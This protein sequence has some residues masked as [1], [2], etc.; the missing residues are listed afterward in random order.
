MNIIKW[1]LSGDV[2]IVYQVKRDILGIDDMQFKTRIEKEGY[3]RDFLERQNIN[4]HWGRSFYQPKWTSSHYTLLDL[5]NL[6]I[7]KTSAI[8]R[9]IEKILDEN[10]E[11]DGGVN[12]HRSVP[13]SDVCIN[14]MALDYM[15]WFGAQ[16]NKLESIVDFIISQHMPDGGF[17]C[18]LN[19]SGAVHSSLH[20]TLSVLEGIR[21]YEEQGYSYRLHDLLEIEKKGREFILEHRLYKSDKTGEIISKSFL[22]LS[23][24]SRWKYDIL[25]ALVYFANAGVPYDDRMNDAL[26]VLVCKQ[27]KNGTWPVQAKHPG[28]VHFD[29][30]KT[31]SDSRWN[32]YRALKVLVKYRKSH[33]MNRVLDKLSLEFDRANVKYGIGAS[34]LLKTWGLSEFANDIDIIISYEDREKAIRVLDELGVEKSEKNLELYSTELFKTYNVDGINID[35][36][37]NFTIKTDEGSYTYP[38]DDDRITGMKVLQCENIPTMS[39]ENWLVAYDL[40]KRKVKA[41]KIKNHLV[42]NGFN[43]RIIEDALEKELNKDTRKMLAELLN[44]K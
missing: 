44:L 42:Q 17:N 22:M 39:L 23:Y 7:G 33:I 1:L 21:T 15:C 2:S 29:M 27:R 32:T 11:E 31:G 36:M 20:S 19:Y 40:I 8:E 28:K 41:E 30:E 34:L 24:P 35:I 3:G 37:S 38:F 5:K 18:R 13:K 16:E 9:T 43:R 10:I 25:R 14:G 26:D 6:N 4:G 12:P